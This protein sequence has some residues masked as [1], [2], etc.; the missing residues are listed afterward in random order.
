MLWR[1]LGHLLMRDRHRFSEAEE[2]FRNAIE[3]GEQSAWHD[4]GWLLAAAGALG[5]GKARLPRS[6][7]R[8]TPGG[9]FGS[10]RAPAQAAVPSPR[11]GHHAYPAPAATQR[12]SFTSTD[13]APS[14]MISRGRLSSVMRQTTGGET[15]I[16]RQEQQRRSSPPRRRGSCSAGGVP[17][18]DPLRRTRALG[19]CPVQEKAEADARHS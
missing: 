4:I 1:N 8:R 3:A 9:A 16:A 13:A 5:R 7:S 12:A 2:A 10:Q 17:F 6:D 15:F 18:A 14:S 11:L 19:A